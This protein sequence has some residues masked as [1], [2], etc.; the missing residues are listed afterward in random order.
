MNP[1]PL[2]DRVTRRTTLALIAGSGAG[3]TTIGTTLARSDRDRRRDGVGSRHQQN[4][5]EVVGRASVEGTREIA[6]AENYVYIAATGVREA[7]EG[8]ERFGGLAVVDWGEPDAPETVDRVELPADEFPTPETQDVAIDD[9]I[10]GLANDSS[11][12][13]PGGI[14]FFDV[15]DPTDVGRLSVYNPNAAI[16]NHVIDGDYAYLVINEPTWIDSDERPAVDQVQPLGETGIEIVDI[17]DPARPARASQW[18]LKDALPEYARAGVNYSHDLFVQDDLAYVAYWDAGVIVLDV[19]DPTDPELRSQFGAAPEA[20]EPIPPLDVDADPDEFIEA[21][22]RERYYSLPGNVHYVEPSPD[23]DYLYAGAETF[24]GEPGGIDVWD[25]TD[26]DDPKDVAHIDAPPGGEEIDPGAELDP[27][28]REVLLR[29][30]TVHNF[31]VLEERLHSAWYG[32]GVRVHDVSD[33]A[34]PAEVASFQ[35]EDATFWSAFSA[36][37]GTI[38]SDIDRGVV[39]LQ[40]E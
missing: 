8:R 12:P 11:F 18:K 9:D 7:D 22:P 23:G 17:S 38:A 27:E 37:E 30:H 21:F 40:A 33:P 29:L 26:L 34:S 5:L 15:S 24:L 6:V 19:S 2:S 25:V 3:A 36:D 28:D 39:V 20:D 14:V 16:H 4:G 13:Y 35:D 32:G 10:A 1:S 31:D